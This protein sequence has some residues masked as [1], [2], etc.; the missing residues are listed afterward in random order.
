MSQ[1]TVKFENITITNVEGNNF[2][3]AIQE[4]LRLFEELHCTELP[5]YKFT[6]EQT[7]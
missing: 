1:F 5:L 4:V 6:T 3:D 7:K 2:N